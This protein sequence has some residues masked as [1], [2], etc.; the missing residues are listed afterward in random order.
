M[1]DRISDREKAVMVRNA[2]FAANRQRD[3][4]QA[5]RKGSTFS[6]GGGEDSNIKQAGS[7]D[8]NIKQAG[9][10]DSKIRNADDGSAFRQKTTVRRDTPPA[11][12]PFEPTVTP[13]AN[14]ENDPFWTSIVT[15]PGG[16]FGVSVKKGYLIYQSNTP[17]AQASEMG[18]AGYVVPKITGFSLEDEEVPPLELPALES[19][20]YLRVQTDS[21]GFPKI[22]GGAEG[23]TI[24]AFDEEQASTH[25]IRSSPSSGETEGD[26]YFLILQTE[27]DGGSPAKPRP[28][29]RIP[30]NRGMPNQ[31]I[32]ILNLGDSDEGGRQEI[33][34][35][36]DI[37]IDKHDF[38]AILQQ[39]TSG[40]P[41]IEP[42]AP[43]KDA[44]PP[45]LDEEGVVITGGE[46]A[47]PPEE[48]GDYIR[49]RT[50]A[51]RSAE[52][53]EG[54]P[55][56]IVEEEVSKIADE[57]GRKRKFIKV[58]GNKVNETHSDVRSFD[59]SII[60]GLVA[61]FAPSEG[62]GWWGTI[63]WI[64][65]PA[66]GSPINVDL[67]FEDGVLF[68]VRQNGADIPGTKGAPGSIA[69]VTSDS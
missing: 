58:R 55:Q 12:A 15:L 40:V 28:V 10:K 45:K 1:N 68:R 43:G 3:R 34:Q 14:P 11:A 57:T 56:I 54:N 69:H 32:E 2:E 9:S 17:A 6:S 50:I 7:K 35:G 44:V 42:L 23:V 26:Y 24:E 25:H 64:F 41:L 21:D 47:I 46:P 22:E 66:L 29:R 39:Q 61:Q 60:D 36:Y 18:V 8:S 38:R 16:A 37:S 31:L 62:S 4:D 5:D 19:W 13:T 65:Y 52:G 27:S 51:D 67:D 30:G 48:P 53:S 33:Y 63:Q 20:V 49:W 59:I